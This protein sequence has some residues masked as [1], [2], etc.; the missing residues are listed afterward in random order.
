MWPFGVAGV[1]GHQVA[2]G[3]GVGAA[4]AASPTA[5]ARG[6]FCAAAV[7]AGGR[8]AGTWFLIGGMERRYA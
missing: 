3:V 8:S 1:T 7:S 2:V 5:T 6:Y 4:S